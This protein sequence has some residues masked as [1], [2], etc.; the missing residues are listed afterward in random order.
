MDVARP[1]LYSVGVEKLDFFCLFA[2]AVK[3]FT[4]F[5]W[6][7]GKNQSNFAVASFT[8]YMNLYERWNNDFFSP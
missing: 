3:I 8:N 1:F 6:N 7:F 2:D 4:S 5:I